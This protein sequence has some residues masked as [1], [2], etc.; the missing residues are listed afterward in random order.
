MKLT[1]TLDSDEEYRDYFDK[2]RKYFINNGKAPL[3]IED[4]FFEII[5]LS[6]FPIDHQIELTLRQI[7]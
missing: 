6:F 4:H 1:F 5:D 7:T 3:K 2:F